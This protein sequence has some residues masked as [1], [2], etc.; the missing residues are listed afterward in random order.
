MSNIKESIE[1]FYS[2]DYGKYY[3]GKCEEVI[4]SLNLLVLHYLYAALQLF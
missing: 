3:I 2:T 1:P 4:N